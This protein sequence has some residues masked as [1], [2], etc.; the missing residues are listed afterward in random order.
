[1]QTGKTLNPRSEAKYAFEG[2]IHY[3]TYIMRPCD[4]HR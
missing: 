3:I 1:M 2:N 4:C